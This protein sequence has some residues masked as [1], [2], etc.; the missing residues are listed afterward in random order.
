M[1]TH[2]Y[3]SLYPHFSGEKQVGYIQFCSLHL[4][5]HFVESV[6]IW[7]NDCNNERD[8][9]FVCVASVLF[10]PRNRSICNIVIQYDPRTTNFLEAWHKRFSIVV[11]EPHFNIYK[12]LVRPR[13]SSRERRNSQTP[14]KRD[15]AWNK[16]ILEVVQKHETRSVL[17][18]LQRIAHNITYK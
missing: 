12:F 6:H 13:Q 17:D 11:G 5:Y 9:S 18:F 2:F 8:D 14:K 1:S 15:I 4:I 16:Y 7:H 3:L 10:N